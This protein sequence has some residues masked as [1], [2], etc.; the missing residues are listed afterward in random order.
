MI[1]GYYGADV[2]ANFPDAFMNLPHEPMR[3]PH[4][5]SRHAVCYADAELHHADFRVAGKKTATVEKIGETRAGNK[6]PE[7]LVKHVAEDGLVL[8]GWQPGG[9]RTPVSVPHAQFVGA[10][11]AWV[12]G[13]MPG[14]AR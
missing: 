11:K 2:R 14:L 1:E 6:T 10:F 4:L 9:Q 3:M 5:I 7:Q 8:W 12:S 13:G